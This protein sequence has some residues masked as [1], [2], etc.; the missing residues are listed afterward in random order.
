[1][2][3]ALLDGEG[4][5]R[6]GWRLL[7]YVLVFTLCGGAAS[8]LGH[9]LRNTLPRW[10]RGLEVLV[11][12]GGACVLGFRM[13]RLRMDRRPWDWLGLTFSSR[14]VRAL[15][16]GFGT[17][18]L[19]LV[20]VFCVEWQLGWIE[21]TWVAERRRLSA[22]LG[23]LFAALAIGLLEEL[24]LRGAFLQNLGERFPLWAATLGTG[25]VFG[26][27]H[28]ANPA[29]HVDVAFVASAAL[30]TLMLVLA[31][32][33]T[34]TLGWAI[35]WHA[36]WD[37][38]QDLLGIANVGDEKHHQLV[39]VV[40]HGPVAWTG[41][42][43]SIEGGGLAI[44][45]IGVAAAALWMVSRRRGVA[46]REPLERGEPRRSAEVAGAALPSSA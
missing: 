37:W 3:R 11:V 17:G 38:T 39:S 10:L 5:L 1:M 26:L 23:G 20:V 21:P 29:Q 40:Q 13:L 34:G 33:V 6:V 41:Q 14:T 31:R 12:G 25:V 24:L 42:S 8:A 19:M 32:F 4:R 27:L 46:W 43:P 16:W 7:I 22:V 9:A 2:R 45:F 18:V 36:A 30:A 35:G 28:L 15:F 44:A